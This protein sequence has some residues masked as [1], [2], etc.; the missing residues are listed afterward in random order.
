[1]QRKYSEAQNKAT[2]KYIKNTYDTFTI[3]VPKGMRDVYKA[4]AESNGIS[5]NRLVIELLEK[6]MGANE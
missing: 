1:M 4:H 2:Q 3:R 6:N 5:L